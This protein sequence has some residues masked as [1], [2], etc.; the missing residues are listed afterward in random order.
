M[1]KAEFFKS[2]LHYTTAR[3]SEELWQEIE[4]AYKAKGRHYH[5]LNHLDNLVAELTPFQSQFQLWDTIVFAIA[6]HDVIYSIVKKENEEQSA[7][8]AMKRLQS[9]G[10]DERQMA[11]CHTLIMA[12][13]K[14][15]PGDHETN[16]FTDADLS[17]LGAKPDDYT[18]YAAQVRAEYSIYPDVI[19]N[20]GRKKMLKHFLS[21]RR[22]FKTTQFFDRYET[23]ARLNL[24]HELIQLA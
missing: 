21:M 23:T 8:L 17:I 20:P 3:Q 6:Y 15:E 19:Y 7:V 11:H 13:K 4:T 1:F 14:H 2:I 22:I 18:R 9:F 16:L 12:T 10:F 5:T 24:Q